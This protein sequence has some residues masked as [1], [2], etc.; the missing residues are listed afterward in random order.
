M[1]KVS[2]IVPNYNHA[3]F[4]EQRIESILNQT[5]QDFEIIYLDDAS[6]DDSNEVF[7]RFSD[8]PR[9]H[10]IFNQSNSGSPFK[11]WNK[12]ISLAQG[13]FIWIA[14]S[15]DY[16]DR[17]LLEKL[18][19]KL[20]DYPEVGVAY[21]QSWIVNEEGQQMGNLINETNDVDSVRWKSDFINNGINECEN[22]LCIKCTIPNA[23]AVL[24]RRS[25][26]ENLDREI[27]KF[28][29]CGDWLFWIKLLL[30]SDIAFVAEPLNY[31]RTHSNT[32]RSTYG[33]NWLDLEERIDLLNFLTENI[34]IPRDTLKNLFQ[35]LLNF[36][37]DYLMYSLKTRLLF[38]SFEI[39]RFYRIYK[40]L[41]K[42]YVTSGDTLD[43]HIHTE[44]SRILFLRL[45]R[46]KSK[47]KL[48]ARLK[49][50][51]GT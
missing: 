8:N 17:T 32:C 10:S 2:V 42:V 5:F 36:Y 7:A 18:V 43:F 33:K 3:A 47:L 13:Q 50:V 40:K 6:N 11:Q 34:D 27:E 31:F 35:N 1:P 48:Q 22:Y 37:A 26:C 20:D 29:L 41:Y 14:E 45:L 38:R 46:L 9:I 30:M 25:L 15:D 23:S 4:L 28:R 24:F 21:C 16:A 19:K 49:N 51:L 39:R 44:A 12:G